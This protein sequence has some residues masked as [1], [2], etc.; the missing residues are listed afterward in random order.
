MVQLGTLQVHEGQVEGVSMVLQW[1]TGG[2]GGVIDESSI[3]A[4]Q[5]FPGGVVGGSDP[6]VRCMVLP[7]VLDNNLFLGKDSPY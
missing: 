7:Y 6:N 4:L 2:G 5:G 3:C 1:M